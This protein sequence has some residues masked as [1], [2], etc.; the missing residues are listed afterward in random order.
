[1]RSTTTTPTLVALGGTHRA[2][3]CSRAVL[4]HALDVAQADGAVVEFIDLG[5]LDLPM[6]RADY[7]LADYPA[8]ARAAL[9]HFAAVCR[10]AD[11]MLW[12][13]PTYHGT[14]SGLFKNALDHIELL[15]EDARPYLSGRAVGLISIND[16]KPFSAMAN[17]VHELRAWVA[18]THI[19]LDK[20]AF[21]DEMRLSDSSA[22]R[23]VER[24]VRELLAF[25]AR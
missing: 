25:A 21:D 6:Y 14:V 3:S 22:Q 23:R 11:A 20:R 19:V 13:C 17:A 2:R 10:R 9:E 1:M 7:A 8:D 18:P 24:L 4:R 5:V 16:S 15:S 12:A